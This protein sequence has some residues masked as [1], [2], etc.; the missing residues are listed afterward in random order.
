MDDSDRTPNYRH[1]IADGD[2]GSPLHPKAI[3]APAFRVQPSV[4]IAHDSTGIRRWFDPGPR[5]HSA[6]NRLPPASILASPC[7]ERRRPDASAGE[8]EQRNRSFIAT[9]AFLSGGVTEPACG[10]TKCDEAAADG[11]RSKRSR[12]A[13]DAPQMRI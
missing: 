9:R 8:A 3:K 13:T 4:L 10:G 12:G 2:R 7:G 1:H 11:E 5:K 6:L